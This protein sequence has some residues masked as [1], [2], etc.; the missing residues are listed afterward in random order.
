MLSEIERQMCRDYKARLDAQQ[1]QR[2]AHAVKLARM[3]SQENERREN[4][5]K[6]Y[7]EPPKPIVKP[8]QEINPILK[9]YMSR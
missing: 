7:S 3:K 8:E 4:I 9:H 6:Q 1:T 2:G 5:L